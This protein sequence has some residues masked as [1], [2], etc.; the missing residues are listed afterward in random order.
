MN[1]LFSD[2]TVRRM[3][4]PNSKMHNTLSTVSVAAVDVADAEGGVANDEQKE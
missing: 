2:T 3:W 1:A 4:V